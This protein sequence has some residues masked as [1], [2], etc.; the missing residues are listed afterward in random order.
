MSI[1]HPVPKAEL[2]EHFT[3]Y[4]WFVGLVPVY[5][6]NLDAVAPTV[7]ERNG[8]PEWY[9]SLAEGLFGLFCRMSSLLSP[10]FEP[11]FPLLITGE[12]KA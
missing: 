3:H 7:T 6:G 11:A 1:F 9:F 10:E 2:R 8:V 4:G 5:I 12:I